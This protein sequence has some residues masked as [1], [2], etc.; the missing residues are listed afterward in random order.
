M[1]DHDSR[2]DPA[3]HRLPILSLRFVA[4]VEIPLLLP[5]KGG[6][7]LRGT[8]GH[9]VYK[10]DVRPFL[11]YL[12]FSQAGAHRQAAPLQRRELSGR[13]RDGSR[14]PRGSTHG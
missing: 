6:S 7:T 9:A 14:T 12:V 8:F 5:T 1:M 13:R 11:P 4:T 3:P 2:P 10:E